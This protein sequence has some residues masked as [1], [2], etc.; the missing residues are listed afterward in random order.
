MRMWTHWVRTSFPG[1]KTE[2]L[3]T[4]GLSLSHSPPG[5]KFGVL[6]EDLPFSKALWLRIS[7]TSGRWHSW[8]TYGSQLP[9]LKAECVSFPALPG[10]TN[11]IH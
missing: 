2:P 1:M 9:G 8:Q 4:R 6:P 3:L 5:H 10:R 11:Q 7:Q